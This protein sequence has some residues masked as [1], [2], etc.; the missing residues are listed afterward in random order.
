[1]AYLEL[2]RNDTAGLLRVS[3]F[4]VLC[5]PEQKIRFDPPIDLEPGYALAIAVM[6]DTKAGN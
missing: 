1:M 2:V 4:G 5:H 3:E 6:G